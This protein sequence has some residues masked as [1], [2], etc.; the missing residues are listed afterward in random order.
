MDEGH[1]ILVSRLPRIPGIDAALLRASDIIPAKHNPECEYLSI[2]A[3][4]W[5]TT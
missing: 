2:S 3:S 4:V 5:N 1:D